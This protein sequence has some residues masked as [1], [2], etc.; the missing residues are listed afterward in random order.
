VPG[1]VVYLTVV[2]ECARDI[3]NTKTVYTI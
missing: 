1:F 3:S 2:F